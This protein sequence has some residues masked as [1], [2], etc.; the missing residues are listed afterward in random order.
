MNALFEACNLC[1]AQSLLTPANVNVLTTQG[2]TALMLVIHQGPSNVVGLVELLLQAG[3]DVSLADDQGHTALMH[4]CMVGRV[5]IVPQLLQAGAD[6]LRR[7]Q[8]G[9]TPMALAAE[10]GHTNVLSLLVRHTSLQLKRVHSL[11]STHY[12][13]S[14]R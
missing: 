2:Q 4:A 13:A 11:R 12:D 3:A 9:Q 6:I 1:V 7:N 14:K 8:Q 10:A 5:S